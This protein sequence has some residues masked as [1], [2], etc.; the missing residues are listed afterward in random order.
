MGILLNPDLSNLNIDILLFKLREFKS[1]LKN[2]EYVND[3]DK[4]VSLFRK[5]N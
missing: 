2:Y 4:W 5:L 3:Y 1:Y